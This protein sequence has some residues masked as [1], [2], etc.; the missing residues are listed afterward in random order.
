MQNGF[1]KYRVGD[2]IF[3]VCAEI[4]CEEAPFLWPVDYDH[5]Q[6]S[7]YANWILP[8]P[9]DLITLVGWRLKARKQRNNGTSSSDPR[10][11]NKHSHNA[12]ASTDPTVFIKHLMRSTESSS[13]GALE[14]KLSLNSGQLR[15]YFFPFPRYESKVEEK[16][17]Y[18]ARL[19]SMNSLKILILAASL[20]D[21]TRH[22]E[23]TFPTVDIDPRPNCKPL[24]PTETGSMLRVLDQDELYARLGSAW[25]L[26]IRDRR[27]PNNR[28]NFEDL[29]WLVKK[30]AV[31]ASALWSKHTIFEKRCIAKVARRKRMCAWSDYLGS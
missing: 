25:R 26:H 7:G 18:P 9:E 2:T 14:T 13:W 21:R 24:R 20:K 12:T 22:G 31:I 5:F 28:P 11:L 10:E 27:R 19:M 23:S 1:E 15:Q 30:A 8:R 3:A 17:K 29:P 4:L 6:V 16:M